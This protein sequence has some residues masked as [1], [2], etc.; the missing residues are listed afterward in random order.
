LDQFLKFAKHNSPRVVLDSLRIHRTFWLSLP[1]L[2]VSMANRTPSLLTLPKS[3]ALRTAVLDFYLSFIELTARLI[4]LDRIAIREWQSNILPDSTGPPLLAPD[5][6][7]QFHLLVQ[8]RDLSSENDFADFTSASWNRPDTVAYFA[9]QLQTF[10][11][12]SIESLGDLAI[13]LAGVVATIPRL[14][15]ALAPVA[16]VLTDCLHESYRAMRLDLR[17]AT[18]LQQQQLRDAYGLWKSLSSLL[19]VIIEKHIGTLSNEG[20]SLL[21]RALTDMLKVCLQCDHE[22]IIK[23]LEE[24]KTKYPD[25]SPRQTVEAIALEWKVDVLGKLIRS[26]QMQLRVMAVTTMCD[27]LISVWRRL[28]GGLGADHQNPFLCHL[29][30]YLLEIDLVDYIL[31][32]NCHPELITESA[33]IIGFL[34]VTKMYKAAHTDRLWQGITESQDPRVA[35]AVTK[36]TSSSPI[37]LIILDC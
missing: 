11:G 33:N 30:H 19:G 2:I 13:S 16:Q 23:L 4:T 14:A 28:G 35:K 26:S 15:N 7:Q 36:M 10:P 1:G 12:G 34:V 6:L 20:A 9:G 21:I 24:H 22:D 8:R 5:Y 31:G 29:G 25:L 32:P 18:S 27:D 3:P 17:D 37:C